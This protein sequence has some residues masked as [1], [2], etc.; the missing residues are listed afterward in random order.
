[1]DNFERILE[2]LVRYKYDIQI[3]EDNLGRSAL[4]T[5]A[6][7]VGVLDEHLENYQFKEYR[8][9]KLAVDNEDAFISWSSCPCIMDLNV[10][11]E[12][13]IWQLEYLGSE[14]GRVYSKNWKS[15]RFLDYFPNVGV[16]I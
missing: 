6:G 14:E 4:I 16:K 11:E 5:G 7:I 2:I 3:K 15:N 1:M 10:P 13:L 8:Y 9:K 12:R